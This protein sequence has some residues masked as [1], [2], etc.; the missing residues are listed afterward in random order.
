MSYFSF[1]KPSTNLS[2]ALVVTFQLGSKNFDSVSSVVSE[3]FVPVTSSRH[4]ILQ[5]YSSLE[6]RADGTSVPSKVVDHCGQN[7]AFHC[8]VST[9]HLSS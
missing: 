1:A 5:L 2:I 7:A 9:N 8:S 6:K 4:S 3:Q